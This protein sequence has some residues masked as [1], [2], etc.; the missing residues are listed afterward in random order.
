MVLPGALTAG[1]LTMLQHLQGRLCA[2]NPARLT[3]LLLLYCLLW[4]PR[5]HFP[6]HLKTHR[7]H[8]VVLLCIACHQTAHSVSC[9]TVQMRILPHCN[10][11]S[12]AQLAGSTCLA[13]NA[14]DQFL[15]SFHGG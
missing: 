9:T 3:D 13:A 2:G 1:S 4:L 7:S 11:D 14:F 12:H 8:D 6:P 5:H 15:S 10:I